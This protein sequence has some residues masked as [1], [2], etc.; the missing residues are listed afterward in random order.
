MAA[1]PD[2][3]R[4]HPAAPAIEELLCWAMLAYHLIHRAQH[5]MVCSDRTLAS[6]ELLCLAKEIDLLSAS[7]KA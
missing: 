1:C 2:Q 3:D 5:W 6:Q 7:P 4:I